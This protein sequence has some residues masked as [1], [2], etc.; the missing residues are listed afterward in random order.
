MKSA[1]EDLKSS[2]AAKNALE[3]ANSELKATILRQEQEIAQLKGQVETVTAKS[4]FDAKTLSDLQASVA[5]KDTEIAQLKAGAKS[6]GQAA[7][8]LTASQGVDP[9]KLP[10][11]TNAVAIN[12]E[13][14][15]AAMEKEKDPNKKGELAKQAREL[16]GHSGIFGSDKK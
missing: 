13:A 7:A 15:R 8:E 9:A 5:A 11:G 3:T 14:V 4:N 2:V 12:L 16:R 10:N 1:F 6:V